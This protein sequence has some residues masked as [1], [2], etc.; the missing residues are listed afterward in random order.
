M[1]PCR[2]PHDSHGAYIIED[3]TEVT[4]FQQLSDHADLL[5]TRAAGFKGAEISRGQ[6]VMMMSPSGM[7]GLT[8]TRIRQQLDPQVTANAPDHV[9]G[10]DIEVEN[11]GIGVRRTPDIIVIAE[12]ALETMDRPDPQGALLAVEVVSPSNPDNDY[13]GKLR[14]YPAMGIDRYLIVDPRDGTVHQHW[15]IKGHGD[16]ATY[17][18]HTEHAFGESVALGNHFTLDTSVLKRYPQ[19]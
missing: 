1:D 2:H 16:G 14:D 12:D 15:N 8:A 13:V 19:S 9:V 4:I 17:A 10:L 11:P 3:M 6:V 18:N 7:H 5:N